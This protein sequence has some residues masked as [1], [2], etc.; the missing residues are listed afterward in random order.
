MYVHRPAT[1]LPFKLLGLVLF[2]VSSLHPAQAQLG[3]TGFSLIEGAEGSEMGRANAVGDFNGD[4]YDDLAVGMP[5]AEVDGLG[6]AGQVN[7]YYGGPGGWS[8]FEVLSAPIVG[9]TAQ[10]AAR[11]GSALATGDFDN[12]GRDELVIGIPGRTINTAT[13]AGEIAVVSVSPQALIFGNAQFFSQV[14]LPGAP[15]DDDRFGFSLAAGDLSADGIDDLAIGIPFEDIQGPVGLREDVG[16]VNIMYGISGVGLTATGSQLINENSPG[17]GL[18]A[19]VDEFFGFSLAIGQFAHNANT[20][21]AVG[22]PGEVVFGPG[23]HGAVIIFPGAP[24]G[25]DTVAGEEVIFSQM[26][27][28][29]LGSIGDGDEFG[30][31]LAKGNFDGDLWTDLAIGVP[32]ESELGTTESGAVQV[33]YGG[34]VGLTDFGDQFLV[35]SSI[36]TDVDTFDRL[37]MALASGDFDGDGQD[38]LA[39]GAPLDNSLGVANSG[40][41]TVLYGS[42]AGVTFADH[43]V[44][45]MIFFDTLEIGDLF[46]TALAAGRFFNRSSVQDLAV[47]IPR[48]GSPVGFEPGASLVIRSRSIFSDGFESGDLEAWSDSFP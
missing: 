15:E 12:N 5:E 8:S 3:I 7:V 10:A 38:D 26:T 23:M 48:R 13:F 6:T 46:G 20:D 14:P 18:N 31:S 39:I 41:V 17:V 19:N 1:S 37:G 25:L 34:P 36:D 45:D 30:Y 4:G 24:G 33:L 11:F 44:F 35:E 27:D 42:P 40:E 2:L 16:A 21:L 22:V 32:G 9:G 29:I 43:Q 28:G 47:G